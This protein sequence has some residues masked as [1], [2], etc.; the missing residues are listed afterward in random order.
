MS[1]TRAQVERQIVSRSRGPAA[2]HRHRLIA[3]ARGYAARVIMESLRMSNGRPPSTDIGTVLLHWLLLALLVVL[4]ATGLRIASADAGLGWLAVLDPI[5]PAEHLWYRHL[6]AAAGL[7]AVAV[8]YAVYI[9]RSRLTQ[10]IRLDS[11]RIALLLRGGRPRWASANVITVWALLAALCTEIATGVALLLGAGG[12]W[13][14]LH[15]HA[16]W[17]LL[18]LAVVH[19][20]VHLKY[21]G[22]SQVLR[23]VRPARLVVAPPP[24]DL[25]EL[26][27][28]QL[29]LRE[30]EAQRAAAGPDADVAVAQPP[31]CQRQPQPEVR[32]LI[33]AVV[34]G[35]IVLGLAAALE[36][37]TRPTLKVGAIEKAV[38]PR[39]DGDL[40]DPVWT[41]AP[42]VSVLTQHG[43]NLSGRGDSLVEVRAVHDGDLAYFAFVWTDPTRSLRHLPL[44]KRSDGWYLAHTRHD[45]ADENELHED[46]F[47]VLLARSTLHLIGAAI[48][49]A[50]HPL[51]GKPASLGGRG[52]HY[53]LDGSIADVWQWRASHAGPFGHID[54]CH[55]GQPSESSIEQAQG[56]QRYTGGFARDPGP[57]AYLDN[58]AP[59]PPG[60]YMAPI[61]PRRLP[62][63]AA[64]MMA[65]MG[66]LENDADRSDSEGSRWWM[67]EDESVPYS[68][69]ADSAIKAGTVV[70]GVIIP[71]KL[72]DDATSVRGAARW[73]AGRWVLELARRLDTGSGWDLP[74]ASGTLMWVAVFDH[75]ETRHT[76]HMRPI[77]LEVN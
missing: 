56:R 63:D 28:E 64:A 70:P 76:W 69:G 31:A 50:R 29:T 37:A 13:L 54:N 57:P 26:L 74:L 17:I 55:F 58:F 75:S 68:A 21:G 20:A 60:G 42:V 10:R 25:A 24:P 72:P 49:L 41:S 15:L 22:M 18:G 6:L 19:V 48:H 77:R 36:Q 71:S 33:G 9:V 65:A 44:V 62:V 27:A 39:L 1:R 73:A 32:P 67:A 40:S 4:I 11:A 34:A 52:L 2:R 43:A 23:I 47:A 45:V 7:A 30:R 61:Q 51:P 66:R 35:A 38:A 53:T 16:T 14:R 5:L 12:L 8:A 3:A 46:K 59:E